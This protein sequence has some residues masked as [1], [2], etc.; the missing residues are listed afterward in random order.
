MITVYGYRTENSTA[1]GLTEKGKKAL[2]D[3]EGFETFEKEI[4]EGPFLND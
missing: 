2:E 4:R 1:I 3:V